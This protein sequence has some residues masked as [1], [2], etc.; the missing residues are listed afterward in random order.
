MKVEIIKAYCK[1]T[2][3]KFCLEINKEGTIK[4]VTNF[5]EISEDENKILKSTISLSN[6]STA[7]S[8]LPCR[9]GKRDVGKCNCP[10][11]QRRCNIKDEYNFQCIYCN[12]LEIEK[13]KGKDLKIYVTSANYDNIAEV[14]N[15]MK[16]KY[17]SFS[18][19][20]DC[21][22]LFINCGTPDNI[23][24]KDLK[25]Y[26]YKGGQVYLSDLASRY[27]KEC[28]PEMVTFS[29]S[30]QPCKLQASVEDPDLIQYVGKE[31]TVE[32]DLGYWSLITSTKAKVLLRSKSSLSQLQTA[33]KPLMISFEYGQ[34]KVFYTSFHNHKQA[35]ESE[36]VLLQVLVLK[37]MAEKADM[38][39]EDMNKLIGLNLKIK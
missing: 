6:L 28:F 29:N 36:K 34:G 8:L 9:C 38:S 14:L 16:V 20:Y 23:I 21:D 1:K 24:S 2:G 13:P 26:I 18:G 15:S 32:L 25:D 3:K 35:S 5:I 10:K 12:E 31:I 33:K 19:K 22:I 27:V 17:E 39:I 7:S 11:L 4:K 37:Q 30:T